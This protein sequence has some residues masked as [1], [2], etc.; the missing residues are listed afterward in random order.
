MATRPSGFAGFSI[1][2]VGQ[3]LSALGTRMTNF[4]LGI[5]LWLETGRA[6]DL[7]LLLLVGF[8]S[9]ALCSPLA[10]SIVD[11][12]NRRLTIVISDVGS[13]V[14]T[15]GLIVL[16]L[17]GGLSFGLLLLVNGITGAFLAFQLP[18]YAST[19]SLM[20]EKHQFPKAN[21]MLWMV[22]SLPAIFA[23]AIAAAVLVVLDIKI[24][25][26]IDTISYVLAIGTV[27]LVRIPELADRG[28]AAK[29]RVMRDTL[30]GFRYVLTRPPLIGLEIIMVSIS[31]LAA[32]GWGLLRSIV[33]A[34]TGNSEEIAGLVFSIGAVGGVVGSMLIGWLKP[35]ANKMRRILLAILVFSIVGRLMF[36][37]TTEVAVWAVSMFVVYLC[38]P[39][40]DGYA[41]SIWQVKVEPAMQGRVFGA[42]QFVENLAVPLGF[43]STGLLADYVFEPAMREGGS[44]AGTFGWL[45]GTGPGAG[46]GLMF[47]I[48]GLLGIL[49]AV[50]GY[51]VPTIRKVESLI[52]DHE[53]PD[54]VEPVEATET[55]KSTKDSEDTAERV[56]VKD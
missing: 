27:F 6:S 26:L 36:G 48:A 32:V 1:L 13:M 19:I 16:M 10:G 43:L 14:A 55:R 34:R 9:T 31:F 7:T 53:E 28:T 24:V 17:T 52:P 42:V 2:W 30:T 38:I 25:L 21:A 12:W 15:G 35:T 5:W 51:L 49:V 4:S 37:I 39:F 45:V 50:V 41:M 3:V 23:P 40:I 22:R 20:M 29:T 11:R 18:A 46:M 33:M 54:P 56:L 8:G 44:L 47:V